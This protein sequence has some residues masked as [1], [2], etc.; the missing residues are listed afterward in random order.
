MLQNWQ[1]KIFMSFLQITGMK[2]SVYLTID[3]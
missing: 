1:K 2:T 3:I